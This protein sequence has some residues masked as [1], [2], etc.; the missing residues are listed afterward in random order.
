ML[1]K[2]IFSFRLGL[3]Y[4]FNKYPRSTIDSLGTPYDYRSVMHY[5]AYAFSKNR[6]PTIVTKQQGVRLES[7][8][9][10][11]NEQA[12]IICRKHDNVINE[13]RTE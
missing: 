4:A 8:V 2:N 10:N 5:E 12:R 11:A 13:L 1:F 9:H 3:A 6:R 7:N